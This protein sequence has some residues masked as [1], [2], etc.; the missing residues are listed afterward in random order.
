MLTAHYRKQLEM[1]FS[2]NRYAYLVCCEA[3]WLAILAIAWL[4]VLVSRCYQRRLVS[5]IY[6]KHKLYPDRAWQQSISY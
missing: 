2:D 3:V 1:L 4:L 5:R 6:N